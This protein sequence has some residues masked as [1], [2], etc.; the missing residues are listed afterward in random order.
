MCFI[1]M[2]PTAY[3]KEFPHNAL[4]CCFCFLGFIWIWWIWLRW[5]WVVKSWRGSS[6][7]TEPRGRWAGDL[8]QWAENISTPVSVCTELKRQQRRCMFLTLQLDLP[9]L[10]WTCHTLCWNADSFKPDV[11]DCERWDVQLWGNCYPRLTSLEQSCI[12]AVTV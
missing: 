8:V 11:L 3:S 6:E 5:S 7:F 9:M 4:F 2:K 10:L 1:V 12:K